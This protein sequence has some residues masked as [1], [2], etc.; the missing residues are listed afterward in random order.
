MLKED[1]IFLTSL[2]KI[3]RKRYASK[4]QEVDN[5]TQIINNIDQIITTKAYIV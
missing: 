4:M 3:Y 5:I 2:L 1:L